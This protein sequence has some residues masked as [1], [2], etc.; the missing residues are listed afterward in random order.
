LHNKNS[1]WTAFIEKVKEI[2]H[3]SQNTYEWNRNRYVKERY[4]NFIQ[5]IKGIF[6]ETTTERCGSI[7]PLPY[8]SSWRN[9]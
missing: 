4:E 5:I 8:P 3:G 6:E 9:A 2:N 1:D 7:H